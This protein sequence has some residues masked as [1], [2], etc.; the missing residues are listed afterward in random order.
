MSLL[1][2]DT[3][4]SV[5]VDGLDHAE[6][7]AW[8]LDG[9]AYAGGESGQLYRIDIA[10]RNVA[11]FAM[12]GGGFMLGLALDAAHNIYVCDVGNHCVQRVSPGGVVAT[13]STGAV[14][15]PLKTPNYPAFDSHGNLYVS[16]SGDWKADNGY[17]YKI[18]PGG[19]GEVWSRAA[20]EFPNGLCLGPDED[21]LYVVMSVN[22]PR[23]D[24]FQVHA[25]GS[26]GARETYVELP[27]TVPDGVA[28]DSDGNLYISCYR[29]DRIYR[30]SPE[31]A[32][33]V[34]AE[35]Y[36]GTLI[37]APTNIAFCGMDRSILLGAN[38]GRWHLTRY[39]VDAT[40][41]PLHYPHL[42]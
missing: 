31:G 4:I 24:R 6:G 42:G 41:L 28:F 40:G 11:Q 2:N 12:V 29:P 33:E 19:Q 16:D 9:F 39:E 1:D 17:I 35:D 7:L 18:S 5:L 30:M 3:Q 10:R 37:A 27:G 36:E 23:V 8:G 20:R 15:E 26:A 25:D 14:D 34:L 13:Y 38:L 32:L 22:P 21:Y